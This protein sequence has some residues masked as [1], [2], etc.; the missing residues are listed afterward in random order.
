MV[1]K[2]S[3]WRWFYRLV[4]AVIGGAATA[5]SSV[6]GVGVFD[7]THPLD[8]SQVKAIAISG[9][10]VSVVAYI[11]REPLPDDPDIPDTEEDK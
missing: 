10:V 7:P 11:K 9:A 3:A 6:V 1:T 8:Y 4:A 2:D 5:V